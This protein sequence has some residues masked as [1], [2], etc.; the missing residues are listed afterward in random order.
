MPDLKKNFFYSALLTVA[1]YVFPLITYPYVSRVLG[2]TNIGICNFV[3]SIVNYFLVFSTMGISVLGVREIAAA[4]ENRKER[5]RVFSNLLFLNASTTLIAAVVLLVSIFVVPSLIPYRKLLL[6]GVAK[7]LA[8]S[9]FLEW[10]YRGVEEFKYITNRSILIKTLYVVSVFIFIR[11]PEDYGVYYLLLTLAVVLNALVNIVYSRQFVRISLRELR[12]GPFVKPYFLLGLNY[13][14]T[15]M[16][17]SFNVIYLGMVHDA[18][19]VG[20]YTSATK[21]LSIITAF[22]TACTTVLLPRMSAVLSEGKEDVFKSFV[23]KTF[24]IL[25]L[26]GVPLIFLIEMTAGDIIRVLSGAGYEGS[27]I[28]LMIVAPLI[29]VIGLEEILIIQVMMPRKM[30]KR[31]LLNSVCGAIVGLSLNL[32]LVR[33]LKAD[34]SAIVWLCSEAAVF[35][36]A[37]LAVFGKSGDG[38]P[39]KRLLKDVLLYLPLPVLLWFLQMLPIKV[40]LLRLVVCGT[41]AGLYFL[42]VTCVIVKDPVVLGLI[43]PSHHGRNDETD[44]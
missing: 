23:D 18:E 15:S 22:F 21:V 1:N 27:V 5:D 6:V 26:V 16:Y 25:F 14:L 17:T 24:N 28:P 34:G 42:F 13:I 8:N 37:A 32:L 31:I 7:L 43:L 10:L 35:L 20:Y 29:L 12:P 9:L 3:D 19:Q 40:A 44:R 11:K 41:V 36:S 39:W 4:R 33:Y 38:F 2:V 30:D